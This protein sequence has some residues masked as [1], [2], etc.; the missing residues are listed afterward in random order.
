MAFDFTTESRS[1]STGFPNLCHNSRLWQIPASCKS[2]RPRTGRYQARYSFLTSL[3]RHS[4]G[5]AQIFSLE[6]LAATLADTAEQALQKFRWI[7]SSSKRQCAT[8]C[9]SPIELATTF[10]LSIGSRRSED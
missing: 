9:G 5:A 10:A 6:D 2:F 4:P 1:P 7:E 8:I 3:R